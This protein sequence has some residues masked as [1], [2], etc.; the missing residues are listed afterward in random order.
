[1]NGTQLRAV[2]R[3]ESEVAV[4]TISVAVVRVSSTIFISLLNAGGCLNGLSAI[5][6]ATH[7]MPPLLPRLDQDCPVFV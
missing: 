6:T 1:M 7:K 2:G 5:T 4:D 3:T